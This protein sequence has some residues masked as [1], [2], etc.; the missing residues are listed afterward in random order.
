L[1]STI[2]RFIESELRPIGDK[3]WE[4]GELAPEGA[5]RIFVCFKELGSYA[6]AS[7][8]S[9][10]DHVRDRSGVQVHSTDYEFDQYRLDDARGLVVS[11]CGLR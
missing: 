1:I 6:I 5:A 8:A 9:D 2:R 3:V 11:P 4:T 10:I 7:G